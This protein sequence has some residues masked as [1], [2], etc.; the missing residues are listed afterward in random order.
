L[1]VRAAPEPPPA[2]NW[3]GAVVPEPP[4]EKPAKAMAAVEVPRL[5]AL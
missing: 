1:S 5:Q 4:H 3:A 2:T